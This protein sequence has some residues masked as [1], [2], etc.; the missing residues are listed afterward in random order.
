MLDNMTPLQIREA[1]AL[2]KDS[3]EFEASGG[4]TLKCEPLCS[5]RSGLYLCRQSYMRQR[6]RH[7]LGNDPCPGLRC[8]DR[9]I[10][11]E[12]RADLGGGVIGREITVL[13]QTGST[14]DAICESLGQIQRRAWC[15]SPNTKQPGGAARQSLGVDGRE[16]ALV[17][18]PFATQDRPKRFPATH[19]WAAEAISKAI[20]TNFL[21]KQNDQTAKRRRD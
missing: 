6:D 20:Q 16:R 21:S 17:L 3:I 4:I 13:G 7:R 10:A 11:K 19:A 12:L 8:L 18:H 9:L 15:F 1:V 14:N 2:K 5:H